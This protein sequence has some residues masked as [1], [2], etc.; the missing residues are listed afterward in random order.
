[1]GELAELA[2]GEEVDRDVAPEFLAVFVGDAGGF[3][4]VEAIKNRR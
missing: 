2:F 4:A 3:K 1:L